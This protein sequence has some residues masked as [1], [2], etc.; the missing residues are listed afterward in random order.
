[1]ET[2]IISHFMYL[3][4]ASDV[5]EGVGHMKAGLVTTVILQLSITS[6]ETIGEYHKI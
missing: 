1:M 3:S 6:C 2:C 5:R 4:Q